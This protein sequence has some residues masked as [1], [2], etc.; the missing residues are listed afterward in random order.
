MKGLRV[1][2]ENPDENPELDIENVLRSWRKHVKI[3][4]KKRKNDEEKR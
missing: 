3:L 1:Q 4:E 2:L